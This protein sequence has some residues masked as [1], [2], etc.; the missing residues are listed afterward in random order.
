MGKRHDGKGTESSVAVTIKYMIKTK[1][2]KRNKKMIKKKR[3]KRYMLLEIRK[4]KIIV[5]IIFANLK[6]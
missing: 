3:Q 4:S 1:F 5:V 2:I 6:N